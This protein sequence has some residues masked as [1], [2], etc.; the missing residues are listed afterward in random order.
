MSEKLIRGSVLCASGVLNHRGY[1]VQTAPFRT[2]ASWA[3]MYLAHHVAMVPLSQLTIAS[4]RRR[5][6]SS[7]ATTCGFIGLSRRVAR[8]S[9][10]IA[11]T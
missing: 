4:L 11:P 1:S 8:L 6:P 7:Q 2:A 3:G 9:A 10:K 5:F